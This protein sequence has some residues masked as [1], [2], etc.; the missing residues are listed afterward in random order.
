MRVSFASGG[1]QDVNLSQVAPDPASPVGRPVET[2]LQVVSQSGTT[3]HVVDMAPP[4]ANAGSGPVLGNP[5]VTNTGGSNFSVQINAV[6]GVAFDSV[7][8]AA[9]DPLSGGP[10]GASYIQVDFTPA[11][12]SASLLLNLPPSPS[13]HG[14]ICASANSQVPV[15]YA[16][17]HAA[18]AGADVHV[19]RQRTCVTALERGRHVRRGRQHL[20]EL[21]LDG[22]VTVDIVHF[23]R[24]RIGHGAGTARFSLAAN[25]STATRS[26]TVRVADQDVAVTQGAAPPPSG[27]AVQDGIQIPA[28]S[29]VISQQLIQTRPPSPRP[30]A[31]GCS[32]CPVLGQP[33]VTLGSPASTSTS[34]DRSRGRRFRPP[35]LP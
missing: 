30:N 28:Q 33:S 32:T 18:P 25:A 6:N 5:T 15:N 21:F 26:G 17:G 3:S 23:G 24:E 4:R 20:R 35:R 7:I 13:V 27:P 34:S 9:N 29:Q 1:G 10:A 12:T 11:T 31:G 16:D 22:V 19:F 14:A 2:E 8:I